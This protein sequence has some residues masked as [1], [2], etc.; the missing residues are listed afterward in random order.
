MSVT[1]PKINP[2]K[3]AAW[4]A[5]RNLFEAQKDWS[6][7][8]LF[9]N[10]SDRKTT[11]SAEIDGFYLDYSKNLMSTEV[12]AQLLALADEV[13]LKD[14]IKAQFSGVVINE[15]EGRAVGHAQLRNF[16]QL[17]KEVAETLGRVKSFVTQ[18]V[19][20]TFKGY[21]GLPITHIVNVGIGGSDLGP[22]MVCEA[23]TYYQNHLEVRFVSNVDGDHVHEQLKGLRPEQTLFVVVSKT[24]STQETLTNA[25]TIRKWFLSQAP[26][27][28]ISKHF[29]AV[30]SNLEAAETFGIDPKLVFLMWDWVGGRFS[31]WS[32]VGLSIALS[33]GY[34]HFED[35]LRGA[36]A[37]DKH[38][39]T[40]AFD[41]NL[42]V[43]M[44]LISVWY[45]NF[46]GAESECIIPYNQYLNK[47]V[48]Y[49]QQGI[50]ESNGKYVDRNGEEVDYQTGTIIWG[51]TGTNAQHAFFQLIHQGT[52]LIPADFIAFKE[53]FYGERDHHNKL[54]ANCVAQTQALMIGT[55]GENIESPYRVFKGNKP[56]NTLLLDRLTPE[57]LGGLIALYEH[58][59]FS[60]GIIWNIFSYDQWGVELGKK[61]SISILDKLKSS[62]TSIINLTENIEKIDAS[63]AELL[64]RI[65]S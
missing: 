43:I 14:A 17:P 1:L 6:L 23:L 45:N 40:T 59:L 61:L 55:Q 39:S 9:L 58:K 30:S 49:L 12:R 57:R 65:K 15:T 44:A 3:T 28:A 25:Q 10:D 2:T 13:K 26:E 50:M 53:C 5:L 41:Q 34:N 18:V 54:L 35:L 8:D 16:E 60:Q 19:N 32:A 31:L 29:V 52:K 7:T 21:T 36:H 38:F 4:S 47:F 20:G 42:P 22:D 24:F 46:Y 62:S 48:A 33:V 64:H 51:S 27:S 63:T 11:F 37:M 56:T